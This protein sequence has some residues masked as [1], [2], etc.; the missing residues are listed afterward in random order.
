MELHWKIQV[1]GGDSGEPTKEEMDSYLDAQIALGS[2]GRRRQ[3]ERRY[4]EVESRVTAAKWLVRGVG[5]AL[6]G[7][8]LWQG[9]W[10]LWIV[11]A[12]VL[13]MSLVARASKV[14]ESPVRQEA[15]RIFEQREEALIAERARAS[16]RSDRA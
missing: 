8:G 2:E 3:R 12:A 13:L 9:W 5:A 11:G 14:G 7:V 6:L 4:R 10:L 1:A 16:R 15:R